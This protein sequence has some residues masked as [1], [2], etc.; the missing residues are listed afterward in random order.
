MWNIEGVS[1]HH[2]ATIR[3]SSTICLIFVYLGFLSDVCITSFLYLPILIVFL[4]YLFVYLH[5]LILILSYVLRFTY[6]ALI[7]ITMFSL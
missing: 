3:C 1:E 2:A 6:L 5:L 4:L 7:G